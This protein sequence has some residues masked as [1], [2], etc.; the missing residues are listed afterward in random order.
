M[1]LMRK[2]IVIACIAVVV[3]GVVAVWLSQPKRGSV[4]YHKREYQAAFRKGALGELVLDRGV[5][6]IDRIDWRFRR[7]R[8]DF[9]RDALIAAGYFEQKEFIFSNRGPRDGLRALLAEFDT[10]F[11]NGT[12]ILACPIIRRMTPNGVVIAGEKSVM[13]QVE[14]AVQKIDVRETGK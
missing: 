6:A 4:E 2:R 7:K 13:R 1:L 8:I 10:T 12:D 5:S 3:I 11:T 14:G 9:H